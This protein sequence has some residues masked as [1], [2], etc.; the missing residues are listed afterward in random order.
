[1]AARAPYDA[2]MNTTQ[3]GRP[4]RWSLPG[5]VM[6]AVVAA[7]AVALTAG[8][9]TAQYQPAG[10]KAQVAQGKGS[11]LRV[12]DGMEVWDADGPPRRYEVVGRI[13]DERTSG[14]LPRP[15]SGSNV[16]KL[17]REAGGVALIE[18]RREAQDAGYKVL[19]TGAAT[20]RQGPAL[21]QAPA[22]PLTRQATAYLVIRYLD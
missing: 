17:A 1:M 19:G 10:G 18:L 20:E 9:A 15:Q 12:L 11:L 22:V 8:C 2:G 21:G 16:V 5:R 3:D 6:G 7:G 13:D 4:Q 14:A